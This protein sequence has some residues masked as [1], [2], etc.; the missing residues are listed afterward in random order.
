M[1]DRPICL[2]I[3]CVDVGDAGRIR[4]APRAVIACVCPELACLGASASRIEHRCRRL[5]GEQLGRS[6]EHREQAFVHRP[7]H[8]GSAADPIGQGRAVKVE[9]L[10]GINLR[11]PV[12]R[13]VIGIFGHEHLRDRRLGWQSALDQPRRC[14][15]LHHHVLASPA[16]VS[17]PTN[18]K[19]PE[20]SRHD[21]EPLTCIL[22]D[23]MQRVAA[24][25]AGM[26]IDIDH[27]LDARQMRRQRSA[28]HAALCG[29]ACPFG[30]MGRLNLGLAVCRDLLD[31]FQT[32]QHLI[33][34]QRLRAPAE[35]MTLQFFDDLAK[36]LVL[37]PLGNQHRLQRAGIVG[38]SVRRDCHGGIRSCTT[39]R[40]EL[41]KRA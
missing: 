11:L 34:R 33:F 19:H 8:E 36:P 12:Q 22:A 20:L 21:V 38:K 6:L 27:H 23:P 2:A 25:R 9:A 14:W 30:R 15:R 35:A 41:L 4:P 17:G 37:C 3:G 5:V 7:Q 31:F 24:A 10:A 1:R 32:K 29:S 16:G 39:A 13:Q 40:R 28:V 26:V 18:D